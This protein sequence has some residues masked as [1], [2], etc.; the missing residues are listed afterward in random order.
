V[1]ALNDCLHAC[2]ESIVFVERRLL[3]CCPELS[4]LVDGPRLPLHTSPPWLVV[5]LR[6]DLSAPLSYAIASSV[7]LRFL[8]TLLLACVALLQC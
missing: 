1:R 2:R 8:L 7:A 3:V 6:A 4:V 5:A